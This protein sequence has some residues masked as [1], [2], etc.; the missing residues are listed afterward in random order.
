VRPAMLRHVAQRRRSALYCAPRTARSE[1]GPVR[2]G[3]NLGGEVT[4]G[5]PLGIP[6]VRTTRRVALRPKPGES[7]RKCC[8][9]AGCFFSQLL[10][11]VRVTLSWLPISKVTS[12]QEESRGPHARVRGLIWLMPN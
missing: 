2:Y 12:R 7:I 9:N 3:Q 11:L 8:E 4:V 5:Q 6:P 1:G 10:Q